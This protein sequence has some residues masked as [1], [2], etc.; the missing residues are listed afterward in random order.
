M[1]L[2]KSKLFLSISVA[3]LSFLGH[4]AADQFSEEV[5][6][7]FHAGKVIAANLRDYIEEQDYK[8]AL[9][10]IEENLLT[11]DLT[12][13]DPQRIAS[14][15]EEAGKIL[16]RHSEVS[17]V[18]SDQSWMDWME[19]AFRKYNTLADFERGTK[20]TCSLDGTDFKRFAREATKN[21]PHMSNAVLRQTMDEIWTQTKK[22]MSR[23]DSLF[24]F[25]QQDFGAVLVVNGILCVKMSDMS[26]NKDSVLREEGGIWVWS[27]AYS[28]IG[29][30]QNQLRLQRL[31]QNLGLK[32][33]EFERQ[34]H[35]AFENNRAWTYPGVVSYVPAFKNVRRSL[36]GFVGDLQ[37]QL[38]VS[39]KREAAAFAHQR[40]VKQHFF[41]NGNGRLGRILANVILTQAS[42]EPLVVTNDPCYMKATEDGFHD[43]QRFVDFMDDPTCER[44]DRTEL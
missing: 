5:Y 4:A 17:E 10:F 13:A 34:Y 8:A 22:K 18:E 28:G 20:S 35:D 11:T 42:Q 38:K 39:S 33:A 21:L 26:Q 9:R 43:L 7:N 24:E 14:V 25:A 36:L 41:K 6:Q 3:L 2:F 15:I 37:R 40:F 27:L 16:G 19:A 1:F 23:R 31:K 30:H 44:S 12:T 29:M 32:Y